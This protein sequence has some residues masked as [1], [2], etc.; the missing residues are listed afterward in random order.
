[1]EK[2]KRKKW[3]PNYLRIILFIFIIVTISLIGIKITR[4]NIEMSVEQ[5][6]SSQPSEDFDIEDNSVSI[7]ETIANEVEPTIVE[8]EQPTETLKNNNN[9][10]INIDKPTNKVSSSNNKY[11]IKVNYTM[12]VVT[13]YEQN[14]NGD[15]T[16][17]VK[18]MI[19]STGNATPKSG[20][21][22]TSQKM[23]WGNLVGGVYGQYCTRIVN[24]ILFHSV[25]YLTK[26]DKGS[27][28]YWEY[29]KLGTT[30]SAGCVRL[31]VEDAKWIYDNCKTGTKVEFYSDNIPGPLGKPNAQ[32][33]SSEESVRGWDPTDLSE[34]NPW[35]DYKKEKTELQPNVDT[36]DESEENIDKLDTE[37]EEIYITENNVIINNDSQDEL[38]N[39]SNENIDR[40]NENILIEN[41]SL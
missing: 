22:S 23:T 39:V 31:T 6:V 14:P 30:A 10:D 25:P 32:K 3:K 33:I 21:Y 27:L 19:C 28:E 37:N 15:Y 40:L 1:M 41:I 12:N 9:N 4:N 36:V 26:Y 18:A 38:L 2:N 7:D 24:S 29:D 8:I 20:V 34:E 11:Y 16:V 5:E 13:I 17:P 35:R